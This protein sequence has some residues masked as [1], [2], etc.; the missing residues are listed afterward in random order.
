M[1]SSDNLSS[2]PDIFQLRTALQMFIR[3]YDW[4]QVLTMEQAV[5]KIAVTVKYGLLGSSDSLSSDS[6]IV[7][8]R[9][10]LQVSNSHF[11]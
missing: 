2:D 1:G 4:L 5:F 7:Q 8:L 6:D 10:A 3:H 9:M 11:D